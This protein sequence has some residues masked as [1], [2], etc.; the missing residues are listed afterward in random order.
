MRH[1]LIAGTRKYL[2]VN[3]TC[4]TLDEIIDFIKKD[5]N[6]PELAIITAGSAGADWV[7]K[8]YAERNSLTHVELKPYWQTYGK[9][10]GYRN[11][12]RLIKKSDDVIILKYEKSSYIAELESKSESKDLNVYIVHAKIKDK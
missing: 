11:I 3:H 8:I 4:D 1:V 10:A 6:S 5:T 12:D 2:D 7:G 9:S